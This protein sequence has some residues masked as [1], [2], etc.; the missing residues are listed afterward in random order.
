FI[1][2]P[3]L[4]VR[5]DSADALLTEGLSLSNVVSVIIAMITAG[6][7]AWLIAQQRITFATLFTGPRLAL[8]LLL[9]YY[10]FTA[11]W[12]FH[13]AYTVFRTLELVACCILLVHL[14]YREEGLEIAWLLIR[15][16]L[17]ARVI[18]TADTALPNLLD[19][20]YFTF[21]LSNSYSL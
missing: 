14:F 16:L 18:E 3:W 8:S 19:G 9:I 17:I 21:A 13:P 12:S 11:L 7:G 20:R 1:L 2:I 10:F 5:R 15:L 6:Y 4:L